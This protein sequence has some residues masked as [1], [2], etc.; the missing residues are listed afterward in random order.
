MVGVARRQYGDMTQL[1]S[2]VALAGGR[3]AVLAVGRPA[4][5]PWRQT[6]LAWEL[7]TSL[8]GVQATWHSN[9]RTPHWQPPAILFRGPRHLEGPPPAR[10]QHWLTRLVGRAGAWEVVRAP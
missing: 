5:N 6:A 4:V 7:D 10:P 1:V 9:V 3:D 2:A 8:A